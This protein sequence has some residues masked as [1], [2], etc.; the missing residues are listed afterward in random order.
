MASS[1]PTCSN[2][3]TP[4][5]GPYCSQCGQRAGTGALRIGDLASE[6]IGDIFTWDSRL[7]RTL[8][9]LLFKPGFLTAQYI[10]G[11]R[12]RYLPPLRL[13]LVISFVMFLMLSV[14]NTSLTFEKEQLAGPDPTV[15]H[16]TGSDGGERIS[17]GLSEPDSPQWLRDLDQRLQAN[18]HK[19]RDDPGTFSSLMLERMPQMMFLL[20]PLFALLVRI[21]YLLAP[22]H[23]L[24][25]LVFSLHYH[26]FVYLLYIIG[27][28]LE[29]AGVRSDGPLFLL[30]LIYLPLALHR[31]YGT[32]TGGAIGRSVFIYISYAIV[33]L[34]TFAA[35][36][37]LA[38]ALL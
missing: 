14:G 15:S 10:A 13:Y 30:L 24:Q 21:S 9:P 29:W 6:M 27:Q 12:A 32:S 26:S 19:L 2:C 8:W 22:Y 5:D 18:V 20:L 7:W 25:H 28:C 37:V 1:P 16:D 33:L 4:L 35:T 11:R 3:G 17:I 34:L 31:T 23:Y 36:V 38:L